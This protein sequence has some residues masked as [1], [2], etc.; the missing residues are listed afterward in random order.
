[1]VSINTFKDLFPDISLSHTKGIN[2]NLLC[3][4][5]FQCFRQYPIKRIYYNQVCRVDLKILLHNVQAEYLK[6]KILRNV[7]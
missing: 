3:Y 2:L 4:G 5:K 6:A 1:M 7:E